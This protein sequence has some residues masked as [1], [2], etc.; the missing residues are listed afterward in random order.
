[1]VLNHPRIME[2]LPLASNINLGGEIGRRVSEEVELQRSYSGYVWSQWFRQTPLELGT[3]FALLLG[4]GGLIS[5]ASTDFTLSLPLSRRRL[6]LSRAGA[7]LGQWLILALVPSLFVPL[8]SPAV[9]QTYG[10]IEALAHGICLFVGG[11]LFV[12]LAVLLSTI[13]ADVWRPLLVAGTIALAAGFGELLL[14]LPLGIFGVM[15]GETLFRTGD[16]PWTGLLVLSF[17][18]AVMVYG[19]TVSFSRRDF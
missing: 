14:R 13:F 17:A 6:V 9:G 19:A 2:L 4:T 18:S 15:S 7:G 12:S 3:L 11:A 16:L 8:L 10:V 5:H 1:M